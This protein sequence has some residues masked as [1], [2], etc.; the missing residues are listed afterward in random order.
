MI[1]QGMGR[2]LNISLGGILIETREKISKQGEISL[3]LGLGD[4]TLEISADTAHFCKDLNGFFHTGLSFKK[5]DKGKE[6]KIEEYIK[7]FKE[8]ES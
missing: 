4:E 2:T 7:N 3:G 5:C 8:S 1:Q 6:K